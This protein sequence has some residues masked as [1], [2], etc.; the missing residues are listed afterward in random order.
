MKKKSICLISAFAVIL[1]VVGGIY[2]YIDS[3]VKKYDNAFYPNV[4]IE[5]ID[6]TSQTKEQA[7]K[8]LGSVTDKYDQ[9][10]VTVKVG[11]KSYK[12]QLK[13]IGVQYDL[14]QQINDAFKYGKNDKLIEQYNLIKNKE[15][16]EYTV[17]YAIDEAAL[18]TWVETI[19]KN[20]KTHPQNASIHITNGN[21]TVTPDKKGTEIDQ[22]QL[23][24]S[25]VEALNQ[26]KKQDIEVTAVLKE[27]EAPITKKDLENV[28]EKIGTFTTNYSAND[29]N[30]NTNIK[31][32]TKTIDSYLL[33]PGD[34]F[35]FND[36]VG[37]TTADKGYLGA[38][39]YLNGEVVD[40]LGGGVCQVSTTLY[41][42]IIKAGI[43]PDVRY[44][45]SMTVGY[46]P[47]GQDAAIAY[48]YKD[49][50]FTN[51]YNSPVYIEGSVSPTSVTF[52][53]YSTADS[54]PAN[55][56]YQLASSIVSQSA[57]GTQSVTYLETIKDGAVSDRKQLSKDTY[58]AKK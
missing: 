37:D 55:V 11:D 6:L 32:A 49:L 53:L 33:M 25:L 5:G 56:S 34:S 52:T 26:H 43:I 19:E 27:V 29:Y 31:L 54:K 12:K 18:Q 45:H 9:I 20:I 57:G 15:G 8:T 40:S 17:D 14:D 16:K 22:K 4:K 39:S 1:A 24:Q 35:S 13:E 44:N 38:G 23:Q 47:I 21:A 51:P 7:L 58:R 28:R 42:A 48:P 41:N 3:T 36:F 46:V 2:I 30:R 50:K 10:S